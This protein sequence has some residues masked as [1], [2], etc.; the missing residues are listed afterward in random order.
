MVKHVRERLN[1]WE[2]LTEGR[3]S[4]KLQH[5]AK[6]RLI[7]FQE[8]QTIACFPYLIKKKNSIYIYKWNDKLY[9]NPR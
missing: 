9:A 4:K 1:T 6:N 8:G 5:N 7:N 3:G 2:E